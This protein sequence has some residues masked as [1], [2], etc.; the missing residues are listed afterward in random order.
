MSLR[1]E[2][3]THEN[4]KIDP[5]IINLIERFENLKVDEISMTYADVLK[6]IEDDFC[7]PNSGHKI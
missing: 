5:R 7:S 1:Y 4:T 2:V 6:E 3:I